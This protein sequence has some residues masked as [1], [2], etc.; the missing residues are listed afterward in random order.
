LSLHYCVMFESRPWDGSSS[1][2]FL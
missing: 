2:R 1:L